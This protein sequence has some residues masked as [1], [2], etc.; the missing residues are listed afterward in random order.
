M[1]PYMLFLKEVKEQEV[2]QS[3]LRG[4]PRHLQTKII[5]EWYKTLSHYKRA[6]LEREAKAMRTT[7]LAAPKPTATKFIEL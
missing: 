5:Q 7:R 6:E 1:N 3:Q 4:L 2:Y